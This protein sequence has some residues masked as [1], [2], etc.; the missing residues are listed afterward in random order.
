MIETIKKLTFQI[1]LKVDSEQT[2]NTE[3]T[4]TTT[5]ALTNAPLLAN[6]DVVQTGTELCKKFRVCAKGG[7]DIEL[8][9]DLSRPI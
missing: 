4:K 1:H 3:I 6:I 5:N 9:L 7:G 2:N 8:Y